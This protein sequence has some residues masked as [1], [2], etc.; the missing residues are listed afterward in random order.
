MDEK[1]LGWEAIVP[2]A[3]APRAALV[4]NVVVEVGEE[5]YSLERLDEASLEVRN[6]H[7][8]LW[9]RGE[10]IDGSGNSRRV[11]AGMRK[12]ARGL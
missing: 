2:R 3:L 7:F 5:P 11:A 9:R 12:C 1:N 4:E 6:D 10:V 8:P